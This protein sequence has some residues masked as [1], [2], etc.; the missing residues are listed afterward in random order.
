MKTKSFLTAIV[1]ILASATLLTAQNSTYRTI[2]PE[3]VVDLIIG[4]ASGERAL[5]HIIEM[6]AYNHNRPQPVIFILN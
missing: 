6:G 3:S 5:T 2:L 1:L 4:E